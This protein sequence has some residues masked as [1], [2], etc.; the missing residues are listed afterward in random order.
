MQPATMS[1]DKSARSAKRPG[2]NAC[3]PSSSTPNAVTIA[4]TASPRPLIAIQRSAA[5]PPYHTRCR[6]IDEERSCST[7]QEFNH[8]PD[9][10]DNAH[11]PQT[12]VWLREL[13]RGLGPQVTG[14]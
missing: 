4:R 12:K 11:D 3:T 8:G 14:S 9:E 10:N 6:R 2:V 13:V 1:I 5:I 7:M